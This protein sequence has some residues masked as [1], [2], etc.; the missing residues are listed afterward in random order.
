MQRL[1]LGLVLQPP[2]LMRFFAAAAG[3]VAAVLLA[4]L[5]LPGTTVLNE[6]VGPW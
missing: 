3:K 2:Q 6:R 1:P 4:V 5:A